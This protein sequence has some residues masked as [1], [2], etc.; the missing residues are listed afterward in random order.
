[1]HECSECH[2]EVDVVGLGGV[3]ND[4]AS[5]GACYKCRKNARASFGVLYCTECLSA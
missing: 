3:C 2:E 1:M 4:C 5:V